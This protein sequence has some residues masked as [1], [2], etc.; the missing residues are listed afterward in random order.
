MV[1]NE[2]VFVPDQIHHEEVKDGEQHQRDRVSVGIPIY[3]IGDKKTQH[4]KGGGIGP[5]LVPQES[6]HQ[7]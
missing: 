5:D 7:K 1:A 2:L 4:Y 6:G 3:L